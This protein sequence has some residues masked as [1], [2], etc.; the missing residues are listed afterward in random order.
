VLSHELRTPLNAVYGWAR[1]LQVGHMPEA[2]TARALD[3][4]VRN[5]NAQVQLIDDLLD[6]SRIITGNMR[7]DVRAVDLRALVDAAAAAVRPA[8]DGLTICRKPVLDPRA[9]PVP[10]DATRLQ[11]VMWNLLINAVKFTPKGGRV[12]IHL[13]RVNSHVEITVSDTGQGIAA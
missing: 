8:G 9:D 7:L 13:E 5:A 10:G 12:Q 2:E 4:I 3:A 11:Q 6:V 1:M